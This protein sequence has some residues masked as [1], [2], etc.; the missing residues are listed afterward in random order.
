MAIDLT[1]MTGLVFILQGSSII[2]AY[3]IGYW[4]GRRDKINGVM[5]N[6]R[7]VKRYTDSGP[8]ERIGKGA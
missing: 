1:V 7:L 6:D 4:T 2:I 5:A 8:S 3:L